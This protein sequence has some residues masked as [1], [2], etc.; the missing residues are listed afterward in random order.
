MILAVAITTWA[1]IAGAFWAADAI[2][3][4]KADLTR[5][6]NAKK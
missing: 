5:E 1:L 6:R 2:A 4:L 3:Q